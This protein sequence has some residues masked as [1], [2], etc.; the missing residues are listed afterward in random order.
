M[1][2]QD[3]CSLRILFIGPE[4]HG[5]N[6]GGLSRAFRH[7]GH[8]VQI[9]DEERYS[10]RI[11]DR[12]FPRVIGRIFRPLSIL[13]IGRD[14]LRQC[15]LFNPHFVL[16]FKGTFVAPWVLIALKK[17]GIYLINFYPDVSVMCHGPLIPQCLPLYDHVFTTKSFGMKD[18][19]K[20]ANVQSA[21][22]I[23]HGFDSDLSRPLQISP[24]DR[25]RLSADVS[26]IGTWSPKKTEYL[27]ILANTLPDVHM[28]IWGMQW[29]KACSSILKSRIMGV[30]I[31]GDL[32]PMALQCAKVNI[33]LLS[34]RRKGSS[35]GDLI[36]SRTFNIPAC[37]AFMLHERTD[38][39][40]QYFEE[41]IDA[42]C[43]STPQEMVEKVKYYIIHD[44]EREK[45]RLSGYSRCI[46]ENS[47]IH[48]A[49]VIVDHYRRTSVGDEKG[50]WAKIPNK[51]G[52]K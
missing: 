31:I 18:M 52:A 2:D 27:E 32:Y 40:L 42:A 48:R 33:A 50:E 39:F 25:V 7:L 29:E 9:I 23:P 1:K 38:E 12:F 34:E 17:M 49:K 20:N 13:E 45:I 10:F 28:R 41:G 30:E 14:I 11:S 22:F 37:G 8:C 35:S 43:F 4:F 47:L 44:D 16:V 15:A 24:E 6:S 21:E 19:L 5:S 26:F 46:A 3:S 36:T 51:T